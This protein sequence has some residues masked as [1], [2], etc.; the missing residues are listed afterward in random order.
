MLEN[1]NDYVKYN[2]QPPQELRA[3]YDRIKKN[4]G[5]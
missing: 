5:G 1:V 3:E 2:V 4:G